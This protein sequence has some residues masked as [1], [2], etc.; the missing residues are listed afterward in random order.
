MQAG[1]PRAEAPNLRTRTCRGLVLH[2]DVG[3][4][5]RGLLQAI[6]RLVGGAVCPAWPCAAAQPHLTAASQT[7][8][9]QAKPGGLSV[10]ARVVAVDPA[11]PVTVQLDV[12]LP[13]W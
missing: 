12:F 6:G 2:E 3:P 4:G 1:I 13:E 7:A 11:G 5:S 9:L 10:H 8:L